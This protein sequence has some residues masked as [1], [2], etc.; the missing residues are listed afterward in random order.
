MKRR[1]FLKYLGIAVAAPSAVLAV[2]KPEKPWAGFYDFHPF[3]NEEARQ[4]Y[5]QK[6]RAAF[7][8]TKFKPPKCYVGQRIKFGRML[9]NGE[10]IYFRD[11]LDA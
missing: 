1:G 7:K 6:F 8:N 5:I 4:E 2:S 11:I 9:Y 3:P 10:W